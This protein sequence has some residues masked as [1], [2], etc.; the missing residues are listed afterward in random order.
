MNQKLWLYFLFEKEV[1]ISFVLF[2]KFIIEEI[3]SSKTS[4]KDKIACFFEIYLDLF[5][6]LVNLQ[7]NSLL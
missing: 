4:K 7:G 6:S 1:F 5:P 3:T 2:S